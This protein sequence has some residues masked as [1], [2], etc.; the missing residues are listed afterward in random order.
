MPSQCYRKFMVNRSL[1]SKKKFF[2]VNYLFREYRRFKKEKVADT[3]EDPNGAIFEFI[4]NDIVRP[5]ERPKPPTERVSINTD[6]WAVG[7]A[8]NCSSLE[9]LP[10]IQ[11]YKDYYFPKRTPEESQKYRSFFHET[12]NISIRVPTIRHKD[13]KDS[14]LNLKNK[15]GPHTETYKE[16]WI[17]QG[18]FKTMNNRSSVTYNI[19]SNDNNPVSGAVV[20]KILD[21]K[22]TNK[23]KGVAEFSDLTQ[24]Y[25]SNINHKFRNY[26]DDNKNIF[27]VY[28]GIFSHMYDAA[29][30][31]GN[32]VVPFR[33]N[34][35]NLG[36]DY[37]TSNRVGGRVKTYSPKRSK[38]PKSREIK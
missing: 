36:E 34:N 33:N 8:K 18:N 7:T 31:N 11:Q 12:D 4:K 27:H 22:L 28:N 1:S 23:K 25:N 24:P 21:K 6:K 19:L 14:Y 26:Y 32:I 29:H 5:L 17:P 35:G 37:S 3:G 9:R 38:S 20:L 13:E 10:K 15:F 2:N 16:G 30:R